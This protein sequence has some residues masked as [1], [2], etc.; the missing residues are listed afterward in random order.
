MPPTSL[1]ILLSAYACEPGFGSEAAVGWT[2]ASQLG[3]EHEV[4][5]ITRE[6]NRAA[7]EAELAVRPLPRVHFSYFD[8]PP[9][10]RAWKRG[11]R[12]VHL[13][14]F[15]WQIGAYR[16]ARALHEAVA[17]DV[18]HHVTFASVRFPSWMGL[19]GPPFIFGP[20]GG[21]EYSPRALW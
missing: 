2:W 7:I 14:Y 11:N 5:V 3:P 1:K 16:V 10:I 18:V 12:G 21:G 9:W 13:Y 17:F 6:S 20:V 4:H 15:L 19:L 8:L